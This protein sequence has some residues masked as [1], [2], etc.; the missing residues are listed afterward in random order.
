MRRRRPNRSTKAYGGEDAAEDLADRKSESRTPGRDVCWLDRPGGA[1]D[2]GL[3]VEL[4]Q[5]Q[6][7]LTPVE[8]F[9]FVADA[10]DGTGT[11]QLG[12]RGHKRTGNHGVIPQPRGWHARGGARFDS[13]RQWAAIEVRGL[14]GEIRASRGFIPHRAA[15]PDSRVWAT[16]YV[17]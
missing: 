6:E 10:N 4:Q 17:H 5:T 1:H 16:F 12:G 15:K 14:G 13:P 9:L 8:G 2:D 11:R 7:Q 3:M